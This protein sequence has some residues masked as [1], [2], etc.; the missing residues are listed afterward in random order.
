MPTSTITL[1]GNTVT[2]VP[3]PTT[4]PPKMVEPWVS[5]SVAVVTFPFSGQTQ[6]QGSTGADLWGMMLTYAPLTALQAAPLLAWLLQMRGMARAVQLA[7][8]EYTGPQGSPSGSPVIIAETPAASTSLATSGWPVSTAG[9]LKPFDCIQ[10]GYRLHRVLDTVTSDSSG[11]ATFEIWPSLREDASPSTPIIYTNP[12]GLFGLAANK[13][14]WS[15]D[16]TKLT[17]LS[18]PLVEYR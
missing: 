1:D 18:F 12:V 3:L 10:I 7:P 8:P 15:A 11:H 4:P 13:R 6:R 14:N 16:Y 2:L 17:H 5:D 9:L